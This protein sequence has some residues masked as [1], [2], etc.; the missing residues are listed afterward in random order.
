[1][2]KGNIINKNKLNCLDLYIKNKISIILKSKGLTLKEKEIEFEKFFF[3][4][5]KYFY[6]NKDIEYYEN[7][8]KLKNELLNIKFL[9]QIGKT[10]FKKFFEYCSQNKLIDILLEDFILTIRYFRNYSI[11]YL[12]DE[13]VEKLLKY[14]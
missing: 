11:N 7:I 3:E 2:I 9:E 1:M 8:L 12:K 13:L 14:R 10:Y 5:L 4:E 6:L